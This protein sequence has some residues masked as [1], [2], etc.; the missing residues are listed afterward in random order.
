MKQKE[1]FELPE[2]MPK[3]AWDGYVEM[4]QK[5]KKPM[6]VRAMK[7]AFRRLEELGK[8]GW[9]PGMVL[10]QSTFM[11]WQGLFPVKGD[12][13]G[14]KASRKTFDAIRREASTT[15]IGRVGQSYLQ[16]GETVRRALPGGGKRGFDGGIH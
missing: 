4:R 10:D 15:A 3:E 11:C 16:V 5:I 7:M 9:E 12:F 14:E 13:D 2:W 1:L 8:Q 6:T